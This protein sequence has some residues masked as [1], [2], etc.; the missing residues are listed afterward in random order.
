MSYKI[1]SFALTVWL[2]GGLF[3]S[4]SALAQANSED[5]TDF[6]GSTGSRID[7]RTIS[8]G[9]RKVSDQKTETF[10]SLFANVNTSDAKEQSYGKFLA[11]PSFVFARGAF[12]GGVLL[13]NSNII[14]SD[15]SHQKDPRYFQWLL[16]YSR[17]YLTS[18][19]GDR[20]KY[21]TQVKI[22]I[23]KRQRFLLTGVSSYART[24]TGANI[25]RYGLG[26]ASNYNLSGTW[27]IGTSVSWDKK[28]TSLSNTSVLQTSVGVTKK[29]ST[30]AFVDIS[31]ALLTKNDPDELS[32]TS[33][34]AL[35]NGV[36]NFGVTNRGNFIFRF[37]LKFP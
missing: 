5:R 35:S 20:D 8:D 15:T 25:S 21:S 37:S 34:V 29:V 19:A 16:G 12:A 30:T 32:F 1:H 27:S 33:G 31:Y 6:G 13:G 36:A 7:A 17:T 14:G 18:G 4:T 3:S 11:V 10:H 2:L 24:T 22:Q 28:D 23:H 9:L 26:I